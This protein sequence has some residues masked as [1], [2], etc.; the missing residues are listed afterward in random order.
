MFNLRLCNAAVIRYSHLKF[1]HMHLCGMDYWYL[2]PHC[3]KC[4]SF[5]CVAA[6]RYGNACHGPH[7]DSL[8]S[9]S[10]HSQFNSPRL[11]KRE[12]GFPNP[13]RALIGSNQLW[14]VND[15]PYYREYGYV[16]Q[17]VVKPEILT[18]YVKFYLEGQGQSPSKTKGILANVF[19]T[20]GS[21]LVILHWMGD[22]LW[23]GQTQNGVNLDFD[24]I[25]HI[26]GQSRSL[27][28][29]IGTLTKLFCTF[30][31]NLVILAWTGT[32][33]SRG[34]TIDR[35]TDWHTHTDTHTHTD[36]GNDNTRRPKLASGKNRCQMN[37]LVKV[38][39][40]TLGVS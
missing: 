12:A 8:Y 3:Y 25:F 30:G 23:C 28:K 6:I 20:S 11:V 16:F 31:P 32:E 27:H 38:F 36:A 40:T 34:Q 9:G 26:E 29:T 17:V 7:S 19:C 2:S 22:E 10:E 33:L 35:H 13:R 14:R 24:L 15:S 39:W 18:F 1:G 5:G 37:A 21:N 4:N